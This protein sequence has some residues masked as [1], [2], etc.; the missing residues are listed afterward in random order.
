MLEDGYLIVADFIVWKSQISDPIGRDENFK[1]LNPMVEGLDL[2]LEF[3][4]NQLLSRSF[5]L[6]LADLFLAVLDCKFKYTNRVLQSINFSVLLC[7][8]RIQSLVGLFE[9]FYLLL[10]HYVVCHRV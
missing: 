7:Y 5:F 10:E 1:F 2:G 3:R 4:L 6:A 8:D 9:L